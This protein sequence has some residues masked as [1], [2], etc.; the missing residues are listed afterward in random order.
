MTVTAPPGPVLSSPPTVRPRPSTR[1][2]WV[3]GLLTAAAV[4]GALLWIVVAF[5][6]YQQQID[7]F[8]RTTIPGIATVQLADTS[9]RVLYYENT[10]R[11]TTPTLAEL[12]LTVF[13]PRG[14]AVT[15][16]PYAGDLRY[17]VPGE[18]SRVG[19]AIAEFRPTEPGA[20]T[21]TSSPTTGV[22]GTLAV[23][24]DVVRDIAPHA[25]GAVALFLVGGCAGVALLIV[26]GVRRSR[27]IR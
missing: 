10:R 27:G 21:V 5:F 19:R 16:T 25:I 4:I 11:T 6:E 9:T 2:Y 8:P 26:T 17:D 7:R 12:G 18:K 24:D 14:T 15:V 20:Y 3:G 23:G 22:T 13:D 1:G